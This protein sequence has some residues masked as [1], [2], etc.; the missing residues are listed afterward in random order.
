LAAVLERV[1]E[2]EELIGGMPVGRL[3]FHF[4]NWRR[5]MRKDNVTDGAPGRAAGC[6]GGGYSQTFD[7][8]VDAADVR[9]AMIVDSLVNSLSHV[10]RAAV[11]HEYL[12]AVFRSGRGIS[13]EQTLARA[14][15]RVAEWL[16]IRGVY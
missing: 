4:D 13:L 16:V 7:D 10:E 15:L 9:C 12:Y 11:Y 14:R 2:K 5:W 3:E 1:E 6:I 8:M